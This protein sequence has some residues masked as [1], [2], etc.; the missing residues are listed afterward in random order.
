MLRCV[1]CHPS[2]AASSSSY[3][4]PPSKNTQNRV[5]ILKYNAERRLSSLK[6]NVKR[7]HQVEFVR[8]SK[9][10]KEIEVAALDEWQ[11]GKKRKSLPPLSITEFYFF[12]SAIQEV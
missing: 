2:P 3:T 11:N 9:H 4:A 1:V 8:Y 5:G 10:A 6:K 12:R 7:D